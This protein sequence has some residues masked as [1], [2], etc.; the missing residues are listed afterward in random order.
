[1]WDIRNSD[2]ADSGIVAREL[3]SQ[4]LLLIADRTTTEF[5]QLGSSGHLRCVLRWQA[6]LVCLLIS[7]AYN[8]KY[9]MS[10]NGS[11][12]FVLSDPEGCTDARDWIGGFARA[13]GLVKHLEALDHLEVAEHVRVENGV[14]A[15]LEGSQ[16]WFQN[17]CFEAGTTKQERRNAI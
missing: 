12:R 3:L 6:W 5:V 17:C 8:T 15:D 10:Y 16:T 11:V 14:D 7:D 9:M 13:G 1:M 4:M 2:R